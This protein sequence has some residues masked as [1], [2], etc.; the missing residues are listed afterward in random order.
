MYPH[1]KFR[2]LP[3][4]IGALGYAPKCL[5]MYFHQVGLNKIETVKLVWKLQNISAS[6]TFKIC[7]T[8]LRY[9]KPSWFLK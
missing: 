5:E 9:A 6:G 7:K 8:L 1:Y 4:V 2:I 3:I